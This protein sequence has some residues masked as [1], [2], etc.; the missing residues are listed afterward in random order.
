MP[1]RRIKPMKDLEV[2][3]DPKVVKVL[4]EPT[5]AAIMF[6]YLING[7]MT[8]K[9]LADALGKN[10]GTILHHIDKLRDV[11]LVVE[12]RTE[13]TV[14]G[15]IQ[16]YYRATARE[17]RL[18]I[19]GMMEGDAGVAEFA[20]ERLKAMIAALAAYGLNIPES[21][22]EHAMSLLSPLLER[23]NT[24][25]AGL[26]IVNEEVYRRLPSAVRND[27]S[28]IVRKFALDEDQEYRTLRTKWN[29]FLKK[30]KRSE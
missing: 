17:Y 8:V 22:Y 12:E 1:K 26:P 10:P 15:I 2:I 24:V 21:E 18:G 5:R 3:S 19:K 23:E 16:R 11:G 29:R 13:Q 14:T 30:Y 27:A 4:F 7:S 20:R 9:Q 25:S 6:K 28:R